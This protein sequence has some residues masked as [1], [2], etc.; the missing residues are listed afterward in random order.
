MTFKFKNTGNSFEEDKKN[1]NLNKELIQEF[2]I[3]IKLP[4]QK[5][6]KAGETLF[7]MNFD[8]ESQIKDNFKFLLLCR[9]NEK[10]RDPGFGSNLSSLF[11]S[12]NLSEEEL[13][14]LTKLEIKNAVDSYMNPIRISNRDYYLDPTEFSIEKENLNINKS[15]YVLTI[16]YK[17]TG[18]SREEIEIIKKINNSEDVDYILSKTNKVIIKFKTSV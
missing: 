9:K 6:N 2:P 7:K 4:L 11:N 12:N 5:G 10:I 1:S 17:I 3:G 14:S 15:F 13:N 18:Y 8:I 16:I